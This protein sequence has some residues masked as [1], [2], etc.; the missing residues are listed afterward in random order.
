MRLGS[1]NC[2]GG[3]GHA[4]PGGMSIALLSLEGRGQLCSVQSRSETRIEIEPQRILDQQFL[5]R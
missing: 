1:S 4:I 5:V 3:G 2:G